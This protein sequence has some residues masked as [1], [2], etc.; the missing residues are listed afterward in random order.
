[1]NATVPTARPEDLAL[2]RLYH[3]EQTAPDKV[4]LTQPT[5]GGAVREYTWR[6]VMDE[7]RRMATHLKGLGHAPGSRIAIFSKNCAWWFLAD[8]AIWM[9]GHVSVPLYPT[10]AADTI[11]QILDH[12]EAKLLFVGKLDGC[13]GDGFRDPGGC[14]ASRCRSRRRLSGRAGG[15]RSCKVRHRWRSPVAIADELARSCTRR[16]R[17]ASPRA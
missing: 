8:L 6:Q 12:S 7:S 14:R 17:P 3:W 13:A 2:Q 16:G 15:H 1:M 5:G 4:I 9:A 11:R 10:L